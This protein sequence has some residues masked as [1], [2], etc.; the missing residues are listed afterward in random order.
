MADECEGVIDR[1]IVEHGGDIAISMF[2][3]NEIDH[4]F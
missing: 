2:H 1:M 3:Y 4:P